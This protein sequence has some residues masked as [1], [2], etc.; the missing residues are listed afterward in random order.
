MMIY[1][2]VIA[3]ALAVVIFY[4]GYR[5]NEKDV[6]QMQEEIAAR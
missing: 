5:V 6:V 3:S 1:T 2:P 4:L